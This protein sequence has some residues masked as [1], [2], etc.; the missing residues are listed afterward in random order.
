MSVWRRRGVSARTNLMAR[1]RGL[2]FGSVSGISGIPVELEK[3]ARIGVSFWKC[4]AEERD[5]ASG[6]G[7]KVPSRRIPFAWATFCQ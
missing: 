3:R 4:G 5:D 6:V 1:P 2:P 7:V